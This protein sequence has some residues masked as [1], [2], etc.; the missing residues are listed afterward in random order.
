[1]NEGVITNR[2]NIVII[3]TGFAGIAAA[4]RLQQQGEQDF[5]L[6]ERAADVGGVWR[7]NRYPGAA[8]DVESHLY[9]FSFAPN[10][11]W[12]RKFSAQSEIHAYL[13]ECATKFGL[14]DRIRF[15]HEVQRLDWDNAAGEWTTQTNQGP[16]TA[17]VV[18]GAFGALSDPAIPALNGIERFEG[19]MF[20]SARWPETFDPRGKRIAIVGTGASAIQFIPELQPHAEQLFVF[21]RTPAWVLPKEDGP[22]SEDE[23][24]TYHRHPVRMK[25]ERLKLY[26]QREARVIAF[27]NPKLLKSVE[28]MAIRHMEESIKDPAL[29]KKLTP[30]YKIGCKRILLSNNYYPALAQPNVTVDT[31]GIKE[32]KTDAVVDGTGQE[33]PVDAIIFGTGFQVTNLPFAHHVYGRKGHTLHEE[34][35][36]SPYAY[37]GTTVA[38]FPNLFLLQGPNTGLGH[39]S[40]ILMIEAQVDHVMKVLAFKKQKQ[41]DS[42]EPSVEA[43]DRF[44]RETDQS[45]EGTVWTTGGCRSWYLDETGRNSTLWP[46]TTIS[47][48]KKAR[49]FRSADYVGTKV[50][51][52]RYTGQIAES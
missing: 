6:L 9:S 11:D 32:I 19:D 17:P 30:D 23:R 3:G 14:M 52:P 48:R 37:M 10:P 50:T 46:R 18:I 34:W 5:I 51:E 42:I 27:R 44:V 2:A 26:V 38:G 20:H 24:K 28:K 49:D 7:D 40:V 25:T 47:F 4:V 35:Q 33:F 29:R 45:M 12:S 36:G 16:F 21:Q 22:I 43:Q 15:K 39:T 1:M 13:Q 31:A 41:F 8:C